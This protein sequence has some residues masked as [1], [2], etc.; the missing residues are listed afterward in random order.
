[1]YS[2]HVHITLKIFPGLWTWSI[3]SYGFL[4]IQLFNLAAK[5]LVM[6]FKEEPPWQN[7]LL[8]SV[9]YCLYLSNPSF[10]IISPSCLFFRSSFLPVLFTFSP[11]LLITS[12]LNSFDI[13]K[14]LSITALNSLL[15]STLSLWFK[16]Q[17]SYFTSFW[18]CFLR[19]RVKSEVSMNLWSTG[20][21]ILESVLTSIHR[22]KQ[23]GKGFFHLSGTAQETLFSH[24]VQA[25]STRSKVYIHGTEQ[26][27]GRCWSD[28]PSE[29]GTK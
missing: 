27:E 3:I 21:Q 24:L 22:R 16:S 14:L 29:M 18:V 26:S 28:L 23:C 9:V 1:M 5:A 25:K 13:F 7:N 8:S 17:P 15:G 10:Y 4:E 19:S 2:I 12:C 6:N 11:F 20:I